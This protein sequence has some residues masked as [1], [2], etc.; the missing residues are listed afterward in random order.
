M[1]GWLRSLR[2]R[3]EP[4][5]PDG[6]CPGSRCPID[7]T[8]R[9]ASREGLL[10]AGETRE[11]GALYT[12]KCPWCGVTLLAW[13]PSGSAAADGRRLQ[14][15][16]YAVC[17]PGGR[18]I[19]WRQVTVWSCLEATGAGSTEGVTRGAARQ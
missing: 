6:T 10:S 14:W 12:C 11:E 3:P 1:F 2:S 5:W 8:F 18:T 15:H 9:P 13:D 19:T 17:T 4:R 16:M 7:G